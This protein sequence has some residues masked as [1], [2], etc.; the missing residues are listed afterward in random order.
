VESL[1]GFGSF[2]H[3]KP[4]GPDTPT[5]KQ[6]IRDTHHTRNT[7]ENRDIYADS[8]SHRHRGLCQPLAPRELVAFIPGSPD[9]AVFE[10]YSVFGDRDCAGNSCVGRG[11][12]WPGLGRQANGATT[13][14]APCPTSRRLPDRGRRFLPNSQEVDGL[15]PS[16]TQYGEK[17]L[18]TSSIRIL[19]C[20]SFHLDPADSWRCHC[21][22]SSARLQHGIHAAIGSAVTSTVSSWIRFA[23]GAGR[24]RDE[25]QN[26]GMT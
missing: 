21:S 8:G 25:I 9:V 24:P 5:P 18:P 2:S 4:G 17:P 12:G 6:R 23:K 7:L 14:G 15:P 16:S 13:Y 10:P 1:A 3:D 26:L 22:D 20:K 19:T 11:L